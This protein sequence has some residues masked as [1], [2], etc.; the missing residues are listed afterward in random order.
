MRRLSLVLLLMILIA[1]VWSAE[2]QAQ[3]QPQT[4]DWS[5]FMAYG[6]KTPWKTKQATAI[7]SIENDSLHAEILND[8]GEI[9]EKLSGNL[10][11]NKLE[12]TRVIMFSDV[13][14]EPFLGTYTRLVDGK[15]IYEVIV[16]TNEFT[17]IGLNRIRR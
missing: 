11:G 6:G 9:T 15:R 17:F 5:Y 2:P 13:D 3:V 8:K 10:Q 16:L 4:G 7:V 14:K 12:V 1:C